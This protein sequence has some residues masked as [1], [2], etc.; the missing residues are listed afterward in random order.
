MTNRSNELS[1]NRRSLLDDARARLDGWRRWMI[2]FG[3]ALAVSVA[4]VVPFL[5]GHSLH[6]HFD[7]V[8]KYLIG[9]S[10][11]FLFFFVGAAALTYNFWVYWRS[12]KADSQQGRLDSQ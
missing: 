5:K 1:N 6:A 2:G 11:C 9:L 12:V 3:I 8:G 7:P 4:S 10:M